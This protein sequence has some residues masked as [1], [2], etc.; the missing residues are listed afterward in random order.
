MGVG[1]TL[2]VRDRTTVLNIDLVYPEA[3]LNF[4]ASLTQYEAQEKY[5]DI[6]I[7]IRKGFFSLVKRNNNLIQPVLQRG[8]DGRARSQSLCPALKR[9]WVI[10]QT[11]K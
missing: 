8:F 6:C 4:E 7:G 11:L 10:E 2:G 1:C 5:G 9:R 3:F